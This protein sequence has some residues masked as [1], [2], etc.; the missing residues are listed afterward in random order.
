MAR[1]LG[2]R[3]Q[4]VHDAAV[5][6]LPWVCRASQERAPG[7]PK[8]SSALEGRQGPHHRGRIAGDD[9][10]GV[11]PDGGGIVGFRD[12]GV[13]CRGMLFPAL[14]DELE[15]SASILVDILG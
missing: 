1:N 4:R 13:T 6:T 15:T 2:L 8:Q 14:Q 9:A 5:V 10:S 7:A 11:S 12:E 3:H